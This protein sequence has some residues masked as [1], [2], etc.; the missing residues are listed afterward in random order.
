MSGG[1]IDASITT[2][3]HHISAE[4]CP[5]LWQNSTSL[6]G[7]N[8]H[9]VLVFFSEKNTWQKSKCDTPLERGDREEQYDILFGLV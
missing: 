3:Y 5:D 6:V 2:F 4:T 8:G 1:W 9:N 7:M